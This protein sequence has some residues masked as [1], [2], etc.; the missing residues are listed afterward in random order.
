M[1]YTQ[2]EAAEIRVWMS[3]QRERYRKGELVPM[4]AG[5]SEWSATADKQIEPQHAKREGVYVKVCEGGEIIARYKM[6]RP[7]YVPGLSFSDNKSVS[8]KGKK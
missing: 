6:V 2:S 1:S 5:T 3:R 8:K 4:L 7:D